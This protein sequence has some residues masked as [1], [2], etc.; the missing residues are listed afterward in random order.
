MKFPKIHQVLTEGTVGK[1]ELDFAVIKNGRIQAV[2]R[3]SGVYLN[4]LDYM[5]EEQLKHCEGFAF[6]KDLIKLMEDA[7]DIEFRPD[8]LNLKYGVA[9]SAEGMT[10][11]PYKYTG[12]LKNDG[13]ID[14]YDEMFDDYSEPSGKYFQG[15]EALLRHVVS[16]DGKIDVKKWESRDTFFKGLMLSYC[17]LQKIMIPLLNDCD[18]VGTINL[19]FY[20]ATDK[21][22]VERP[23][24]PII[25]ST[26][27]K[28][29]NPES[30]IVFMMPSLKKS[31]K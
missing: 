13:E 31:D 4:A 1:V 2:N 7:D 19:D 5:S 24:Q 8:S 26:S 18:S 16:T 14:M 30:S 11:V 10:T 28:K 12:K 27:E 6:H 25:I 17:E 21:D 29:L 22:K 20:H 15:L 9:G 3:H 23:S